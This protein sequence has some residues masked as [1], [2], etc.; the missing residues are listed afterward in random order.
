MTG[1]SMVWLDI[2][3]PNAKVNSV[4]VTFAAPFIPQKNQKHQIAGSIAGAVWATLD[5]SG[6]LTM[7][8]NTGANQEINGRCMFYLGAIP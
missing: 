1:T 5:T 2:I 3:N 4:V 6:N 8:G 7:T